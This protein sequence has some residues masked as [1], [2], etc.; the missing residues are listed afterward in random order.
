MSDSANQQTVVVTGA[1]GN[2]GKAV[3]HGVR[4]GHGR[5]ASTTRSPTSSVPSHTDRAHIRRLGERG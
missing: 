2:L 5:P 4:P 1:A 3:A